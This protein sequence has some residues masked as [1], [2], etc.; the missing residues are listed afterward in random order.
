[1]LRNKCF[2]SRVR[3]LRVVTFII[4]AMD[5]WVQVKDNENVEHE[6]RRLTA[7]LLIHNT[8]Y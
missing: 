5:G 4:E 2:K 6:H 8:S 3:L 1:M 7:L